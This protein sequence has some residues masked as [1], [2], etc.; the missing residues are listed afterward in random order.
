M[1]PLQYITLE[2][3]VFPNTV[4]WVCQNADNYLKKKNIWRNKF[5]K[6]IQNKDILPFRNTVEIPRFKG[7]SLDTDWTK[8]WEEK[9]SMALCH[10]VLWYLLLCYHFI[11][12]SKNYKMT[13][14]VLNVEWTKNNQLVALPLSAP[15]KLWTCITLCFKQICI[16]IIKNSLTFM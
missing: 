15:W 3:A 10:P 12:F 4:F 16:S 8:H 2:W 9:R 7:C 11:R 5:V 14:W 6:G 13:P 1:K